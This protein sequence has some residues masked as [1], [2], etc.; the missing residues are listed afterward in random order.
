MWKLYIHVQKCLRGVH[1]ANSCLLYSPPDICYICIPGNSRTNARTKPDSWPDAC[2]ICMVQ[3]WVWWSASFMNVDSGK[4]KGLFCPALWLLM[5][6]V[7]VNMLLLF[8]KCHSHCRLDSSCMPASLSA[9][10]KRFS[11]LQILLTCVNMN[12]MVRERTVLCDRLSRHV[13]DVGSGIFRDAGGVKGTLRKHHLTCDGEQH[14]VCW[15]IQRCLQNPLLSPDI[16]M[17]TSVTDCTLLT[18]VISD[19]Q[20][21]DILRDILLRIWVKG[22]T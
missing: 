14:Y 22:Y 20:Q 5:L 9:S 8:R 17:H 12:M 21:V 2:S 4:M 11:L 7:K 16:Y 6:R 1:C 19:L 10:W 18:Y 13:N 15:F 3:D